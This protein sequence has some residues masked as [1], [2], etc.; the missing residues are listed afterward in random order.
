[1]NQRDQ[2]VTIANT[3]LSQAVNNATTITNR[4][5]LNAQAILFDAQQKALAIN[6]TYSN[7]LAVYQTAMGIL[8]MNASDYIRSV[9]QTKLL[10]TGDH[11]KV[12]V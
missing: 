10:S 3:L 8:G 4:A 6:A 2:S 12:F 1:M 11:V 9:L 5:N 7:R